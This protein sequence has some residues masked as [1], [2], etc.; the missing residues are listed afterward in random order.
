MEVKS[1]WSSALSGIQKGMRDLDANAAKIAHATT[2][3]GKEDVAKPLVESRV[4]AQQVAVNAK[5]IDI[6]DE[7]LGSLFDDKA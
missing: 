1:A 5:V 6:V 4:D 3:E 7:T 2:T